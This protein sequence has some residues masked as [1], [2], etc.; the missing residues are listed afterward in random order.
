MPRTLIGKGN[1]VVLGLPPGFVLEEV[2]KKA[3]KDSAWN[4]F[5]PS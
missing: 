2:L 1:A 5:C 3:E 4:C